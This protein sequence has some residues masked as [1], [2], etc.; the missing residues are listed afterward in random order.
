MKSYR[1]LIVEDHPFQH[2]YLLHLFSDLGG[3]QVDAVWD[4]PTA[5][6]RLSSS[7]Y[8]LVVSDLFMPGMDGVQLIEKLAGLPD[9]PAL[10][11]M[12]VASRRMLV[13]AG[14]AAK[15]LGLN[16]IG[17]ISKPVEAQAIV[18]LRDGLDALRKRGSAP[19]GSPLRHDRQRLLQAM[20][21]GQIQPWF[22]PKKSLKDGRICGAE[23]LVRW[24]HPQLGTLMPGDFLAAIE[25]LALEEE[26]LWL[27]L[28]RTLEVQAYWRKRG[29]E[30]SVS[31]NLP[32]HLLDSHDLSDRLH[33]RVLALGGEPRSIC[34]ELLE[35]STTQA[36]SAY[37]AGACRLR[38][39]G[40]GLAQD[41]F[42]KGF[43]SYFNLISTPFSELKI[44]RSLVNGCV[45]NESMAAA[46]QSIVELSG[47]L[48]LT[49]TAEGVETQAELAFLR[50][51]RCD[52]AQ[53]FLIC[54]AVAPE[55]FLDLL[56]E[57]GQT[58]ALK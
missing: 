30:V 42:G 32:T 54:A 34:F 2:E 23:A 7:H 31:I 41:D 52:Q 21:S 1:V 43:S 48:G 12:S 35:T 45:E 36:L 4:G 24:Q 13:S 51:I 5:L 10:A 16:V 55:L 26:L 47:K 46:L 44:D 50:K 8:D 11:L 58:P 28:E 19:V 29:Y 6:T 38:M 15:N 14:L 56:R 27:M 3:F 53:G 57:D 25:R 17:L 22:Q 49:V 37:Y 39:M 20:R 9:C 18:R 40:F 33:A